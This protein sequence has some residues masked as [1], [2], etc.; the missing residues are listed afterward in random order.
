MVWS[1]T[2]IT[3]EI[4]VAVAAGH[5]LGLDTAG[6]RTAIRHSPVA[7][8]W[9]PSRAW[10][11]VHAADAGSGGS[12]RS[13]GGAVGAGGVHQRPTGLAG[14]YGCL[15][16]FSDQPDLDAARVASVAIAASPGAMALCN[17]RNPK[18]EMQARV[19]LHHWIAV[20]FIRGT[21]RIQDMD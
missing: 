12:D 20:A 11:P 13:E 18:D 21:A 8:R 7:G 17:N 19:S 10:Q 4:G 16:V 1:G 6:M 5:L 9:V 14:R 2:G 3:G 15:S